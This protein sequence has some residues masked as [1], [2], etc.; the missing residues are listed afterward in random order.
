MS[1]IFLVELAETPVNLPCQVLIKPDKFWET[2]DFL[3]EE[4]K[5][6]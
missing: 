4:E 3:P 5:R 2:K 1:I 6:N